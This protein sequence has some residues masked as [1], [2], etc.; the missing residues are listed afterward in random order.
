MSHGLEA[1]ALAQAGERLRQE[2]ALFDRRMAQD[3]R[4]FRLRMAM[5][6]VSIVLFVAICS[7]CGYII[8]DSDKFGAGTV[9]VATSA[10]LVE[11]LGLIGA[12]I[13][14]AV[15]V[16]SRTVEPVTAPMT[17]SPSAGNE[18]ASEPT[19]INRRSK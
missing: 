1:V 10:L 15:G 12:T 9:T 4:L 7:F 2:S 6:W 17:V 11:V 19:S 18:L 3:A 8:A 13:K 16:G 5:G 14:G